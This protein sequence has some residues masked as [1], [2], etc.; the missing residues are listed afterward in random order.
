MS[1]DK[2]FNPNTMGFGNISGLEAYHIRDK[3]RWEFQ[4]MLKQLEDLK[5]M[6]DIFANNHQLKI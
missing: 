4:M 5:I 1:K 2:Q 6:L 3:K